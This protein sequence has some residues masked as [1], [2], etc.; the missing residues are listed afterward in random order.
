MAKQKVKLA[1][2]QENIETLVIPEP[3]TETVTEVNEETVVD[4]L[5][6]QEP[7]KIPDSEEVDFLKKILRIQNEGGF[8]THLNKTILERIE[9]L[10][11]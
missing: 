1:D 5:P 7:P 6:S 8:G 9:Q 4:V 3:V 11:K 2:E 10:K